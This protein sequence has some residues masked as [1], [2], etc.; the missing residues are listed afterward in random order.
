MSLSKEFLDK[1]FGEDRKI[2]ME[3]RRKPEKPRI[4][5]RIRSVSLRKYLSKGVENISQVCFTTTPLIFPE[6]M[7]FEEGCKV[8]SYMLV[9]EAGRGALFLHSAENVASLLK[10]LHEFDMK[11][12]RRYSCSDTYCTYPYDP[13]KKIQVKSVFDRE[14]SIDGVQDLFLPD[15]DKGLFEQSNLYDKYFDWVYEDV[16]Q[17]DVEKIYAT[18]EERN[19]FD[20]EDE[21]YRI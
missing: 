12:D 21:F 4:A 9:R 1:I 19:Q 18:V 20:S 6:G 17:E 11:A 14:K 15:C 3:E 13:T 2:I 7:T 10:V 5:V 16:T 8:L